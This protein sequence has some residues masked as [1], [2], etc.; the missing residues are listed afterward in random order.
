MYVLNIPEYV[1]QCF[2]VDIQYKLRII[3]C[4]CLSTH[5]AL[6]SPVYIANFKVMALK[7]GTKLIEMQYK[8]AFVMMSFL[9]KNFMVIFSLP[10][11]SHMA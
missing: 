7:I 11:H 4:A 6:L 8:V 1:A 2:C 10:H 9:F 3:L 5:T